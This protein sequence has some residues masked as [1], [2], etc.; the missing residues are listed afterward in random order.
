MRKLLLCFVVLAAVIV[1]SAE[2]Q[3]ANKDARRPAKAAVQNKTV[4][5]KKAKGDAQQKEQRDERDAL[6][7]KLKSAK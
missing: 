1:Y 7:E 2:V 3:S 6:M 5:Q 4:S